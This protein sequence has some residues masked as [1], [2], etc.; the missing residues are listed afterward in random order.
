MMISFLAQGQNDYKGIIN[1]YDYTSNYINKPKKK[2]TTCISEINEANKDIEN[3]K[4]V[5]CSPVGF[6]FGLLRFEDE[7]KEVVESYGLEFKIDLIS[8]VEKRAKELIDNFQS[9]KLGI[10]SI[11]ESLASSLL[12]L[13]IEQQLK[14]LNIANNK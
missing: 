8:D 14:T 5:F 6:I 11:I 9:K 1:Y 13:N 4:I 10:D 3:G 7:L 12:R 2:D